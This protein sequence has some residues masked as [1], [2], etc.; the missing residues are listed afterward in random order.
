MKLKCPSRRSIHVLSATYGREP[1]LDHGCSL[2]RE[3]VT[4]CSELY[5][6]EIVQR[7]CEGK[8]SCFVRAANSVFGDPCPGAVKY[9]SV[10]YRCDVVSYLF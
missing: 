6:K 1:G 7:E 3:D 8:N 4:K 9:L 10:K 2:N 5:S